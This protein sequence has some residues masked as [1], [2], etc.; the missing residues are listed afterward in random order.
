[1]LM[2]NLSFA[3]QLEREMISTRTK[4][5]FAQ[6]KA[7]GVQLGN[8]RI[9]AIVDRNRSAANVFAEGLRPILEK[10]VDAGKN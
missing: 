8:P 3:A 1:M 4:A 10:L 6:K 5:A 9:H 7:N 2:A